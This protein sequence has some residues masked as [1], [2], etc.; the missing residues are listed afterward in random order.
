M[1]C[2]LLKVEELNTCPLRLDSASYVG[3]FSLI[4]Q[5][6]RL[7]RGRMHVIGWRQSAPGLRGL[8]RQLYPLFKLPNVDNDVQRMEEARTCVQMNDGHGQHDFREPTRHPVYTSYY[9]F[10]VTYICNV[11]LFTSLFLITW[12]VVV[13]DR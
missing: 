13:I 11:V 3:L 7:L 9:L 4:F 1:T 2:T 6:Y 8:G 10:L 12:Q 5:V